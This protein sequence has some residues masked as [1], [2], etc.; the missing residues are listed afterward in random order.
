[1][2]RTTTRM[3]TSRLIAD[4]FI[5]PSATPLYGR[6]WNGSSTL[7]TSINLVEQ[8][9]VEP[10][11]DEGDLPLGV[12]KDSLDNDELDTDRLADTE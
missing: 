6:P 10:D 3:K 4:G 8:D 1:M 9:E 5:A 12:D 7:L 11:E 2:T